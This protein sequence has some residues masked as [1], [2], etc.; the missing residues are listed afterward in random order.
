MGVWRLIPVGQSMMD[1]IF[2]MA[3][4]P[5]PGG[6]AMEVT[7]RLLPG[8]REGEGLVVPLRWEVTGP[9]GALLPA[10]DA[11]LKLVAVDA[12]TSRLSVMG[13]YEPPLGRLGATIDRAAPSRVASATMTALLRKLATQLRD[14]A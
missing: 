6:P 2:V 13:R 14:W 12:A 5:G 4:G 11:N 10:L 7:V 1:L 9:T 3:V 8:R